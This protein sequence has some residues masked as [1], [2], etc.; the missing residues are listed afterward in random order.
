MATN[1][2]DFQRV[3]YRLPRARVTIAGLFWRHQQLIVTSSAE[4]KQGERDTNS[5]C[6]FRLFT[7]MYWAIMSCNK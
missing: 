6:E 3:R 2:I 1:K 4:G 7:V 5:M